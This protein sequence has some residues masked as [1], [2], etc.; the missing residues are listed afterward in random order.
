MLQTSK[1]AQPVVNRLVVIGLGLIG[2][3]LALAARNA[4]LATQ[5]VG[6]SRRSSTLDLALEHGS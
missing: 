1:T 3:S 5:V 4:G 6:I 2:S